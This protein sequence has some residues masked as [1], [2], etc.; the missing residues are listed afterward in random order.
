VLVVDFLPHQQT[1]DDDDHEHEQEIRASLIVIVVVLV[2]D[3]LHRQHTEDIDD[4]EHDHEI[5]ASHPAIESQEAILH[6]LVG[7][8]C[9]Q[10]RI[11]F[12]WVLLRLDDYPATVSG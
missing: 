11:C 9:V 8:L 2:V 5:R 10:P 12:G 4:H 1:E 7:F 3:F 6:V